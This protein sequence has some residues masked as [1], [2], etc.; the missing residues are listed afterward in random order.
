[1][2][3]GDR[4]ALRWTAEGTSAGRLAEWWRNDDSA[5]LRAQVTVL[6]QIQSRRLKTV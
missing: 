6:R 1:M 5:G 3:A 4:V 2:A